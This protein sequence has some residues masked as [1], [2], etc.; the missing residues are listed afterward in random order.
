[1]KTLPLVLDAR[2]DDDRRVNYLNGQDERRSVRFGELRATALGVLRYLQKSGAQ[3][4]DRVIL[5]TTSNEQFVDGFWACLY[6]GLV[7]VPVAVGISDD[8]R[9]KLL[10][11]SSQLGDPLIYTERGQ[12]ARLN[13]FGAAH[14]LERE[15]GTLSARALVVESVTHIDRPGE[16]HTAEPDDVAFIQ[17]SSGST[18]RPK[19]VVLTH[20][21][22]LTNIRAII[23][24]GRFTADD[25]SLSWMPLTHD[26][27]LIGF[28]LCMLAA[29]IEQ[30]LMDTRLFSR[31]PLLWLQEA[32]R[33]GATLLS[34]PNFGYKHF[35]KVHETRPLEGVDL[36]RVRLIFNGAEPIS[37]PLANRFMAEMAPFGLKA[38]AMYPVYGL[39]EASLAVS[40]PEPGSGSRSVAVRRSRL[41]V[42]DA[43]E[44]AVDPGDRLELMTVGTA[45]PGCDLRI[46]GHADEPLR[47]GVVGHI[48]IRG[49]N[50]T[51]G[52]LG[53]PPEE[54]P[55]TAEGWLRTGD[56]GFIDAAAGDLVV[57]GRHKEIIFINGQ[58]Y[59]PHDIESL[60]ERYAGIEL[61]KVAAAAGRSA[62]G[63]EDELLLF[64]IHRGALADFLAPAHQVRRQITEHTGLNVAHVIPVTGLPKTT[65]GKLQ[66]NKLSA[67]YAAGQ[68]T[69]TLAELDA[70]VD[71]LPTSSAD[72]ASKLERAVHGICAGVITDRA[73]G[74]DDDF[75][76][77]GVSSLALAQI[78][79]R[80][81][82]QFPG[83]LDVEDLF[84]KSTIRAVAAHL[85]VDPAA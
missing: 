61:G 77:L 67:A 63:D 21:N 59:Y 19:G 83:R 8:H 45:I 23:D 18:S 35:L 36:S 33:I 13:D 6:G 42:G 41:S 79:E 65:S 55:F 10:Q 3:P 16:R 29:G 34:S 46:A 22:V 37:V 26:M 82:E 30:T 80:I 76:E 24:R 70:L 1:V 7:P 27:G 14:G 5:H 47:S 64:L 49:D 54:Q 48:Q 25:V 73:I 62:S 28:H 31:R 57:T 74:L 69:N 20:R 51:G 71:V 68:Y 72:R 66:R 12:L 17:Y 32:G 58:N 2:A 53:V 39:A 43:A 15:V 9:H 11:V 85:A 40:F 50:V 52:Y 4:G 44:A 78:H 56:L 75:F 81:D 84:S 60:A 38:S